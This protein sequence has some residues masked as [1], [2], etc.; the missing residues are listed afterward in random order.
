VEW[1]FLEAVMRK[2]EFLKVWVKLIMGCVS[3]VFY[4]ILVNGQPI[5]NIK[6]SRG[7]H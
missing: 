7:I 5:G 4:A 1:V 6:P 3:S 2:M